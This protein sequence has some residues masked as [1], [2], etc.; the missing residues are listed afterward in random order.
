MADAAAAAAVVLALPAAEPEA[1][2][3]YALVL[4]E[5]AVAE[6]APGLDN[7]ST[8]QQ[9]L[10]W[11]GFRVEATRE[12]LRMDSLGSFE[13]IQTL[14]MKDVQSIA[15]DWSS[16][17]AVQGR[18]YM[19]SRRLK[20]LQALIHWI[21][22]FRRVSKTP[23]IV[24][25]NELTFKAQLSRALDRSV[26]RM[27]LKDQSSTSSAAASPGP[28]DS[29]RKW[30]QWEEKF[31]NYAASHIGSN[32]IPLSYVI[33]KNDEPATDVEYSD[34]ITETINCAPLSGEF[35]AADRMTVFNMII[36]FTTGQP[37]ADWIKP[38]VKHNNGRRSM[39]ALRAHFAGEGNA[40]RNK[41][42]ADR[43]KESLH[44]KSERAMDFEQF[45]TQCQKMYNIYDNE[46]EPMGEDA[47]IRFL[48]KKVENPNLQSAIQA[49]KVRLATNESL[50]YTQA[51]N[52]LSTAVSE[53]PEYHAK[54][55]NVSAANTSTTSNSSDK[56]SGI[57]NADGSIITGHIASWRNL[58]QADR[59][60]VYAERERLGIG[61]G[62]KGGKGKGKYSSQSDPATATR[63]KQL[64]ESNKRMK[65]QVKALKRK[66]KDDDNDDEDSTTDA[67]DQFGGK[68]SKKSK[69]NK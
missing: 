17:T 61:K 2:V 28:L 27:T 46:G 24:G 16:R 68:A 14:T 8:I 19:G 37:S 41:A 50:S 48:F 54:N 59:N 36:S 47:R 29:E 39:K 26:I 45:L 38:T 63:M 23:T 20:Y 35:Y 12:N 62:N 43:L 67:G 1:T 42:E 69:K 10:H 9:I 33:R 22:D 58:S 64:A 57:Y 21:Q 30:K 44:Y 25:L 51:A 13:E 5:V 49:L 18:F 32:G 60:L 6:D 11:I 66:P 40:S 34:F 65:R 53:L 15:T 56:P 55:R 31:T 4:G 7:E 52:H 3:V